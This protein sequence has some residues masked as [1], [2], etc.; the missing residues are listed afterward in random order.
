MSLIVN[1]GPAFFASVPRVP[2]V[3]ARRDAP[4]GVVVHVLAEETGLIARAI[5]PGSDGASLLSAALELVPPAARKRVAIDFS[6]VG[7]LTALDG[8]PARAT[9]REG[10]GHV[11]EL[12][13]LAGNV[14]LQARHCI[15]GARELVVRQNEDD[16]RFG[17]ALRL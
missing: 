15:L 1:G 11:G 7:V 8:G 14:V 16:V 9:Q 12:D 17:L 13:T 10:G 5:Q 4:I 3:P 6:V 2:A